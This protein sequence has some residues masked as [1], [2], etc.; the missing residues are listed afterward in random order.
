MHCY[1]VLHSGE[2]L[3]GIT[4]STSPL[5]PGV[6]PIQSTMAIIGGTYIAGISP[7]VGDYP[8]L[9]QLI[10]LNHWSSTSFTQFFPIFAGD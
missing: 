7:V 5:S 3:N 1:G 6:H 8:Q 4:S 2:G 9:D 10:Q